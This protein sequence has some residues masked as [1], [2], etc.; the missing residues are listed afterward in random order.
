MNRP[1]TNMNVVVRVT[2][3]ILL[4]FLMLTG[5]AVFVLIVFVP[6][7]GWYIWRQQDRIRDLEARLAALDA[8]KKPDQN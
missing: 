1:Q 6:V 5:F 7:M 8:R 4:A 2:F 3:L